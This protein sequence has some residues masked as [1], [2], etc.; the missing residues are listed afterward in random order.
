MLFELFRFTYRF[1]WRLTIFLIVLLP[2]Q[3]LGAIILLP[4][5]PLHMLEVKLA[6]RSI[7]LPYLL[8]WFDNADQYVGRDTSTYLAVYNSGVWNTYTWLA[9]RNPLNYFGYKVL[10]KTSQLNFNIVDDNIGDATGNTP[11]YRHIEIPDAYEY[12]YIY[13]YGMS[14]KCFRF[15]MGWKLAGAQPGQ[16]CEYVALISPYHSYSGI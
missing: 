15:R 12:Y 1:I 10:G 9:W 16:L 2:L 13:R 8:R 11:G 3:F 14:D 5:L 7:K 6:G 4:F